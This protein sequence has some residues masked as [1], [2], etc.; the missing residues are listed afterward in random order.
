[1]PAPAARR[2]EDRSLELPDRAALLDDT[3]DAERP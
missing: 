3:D 2:A 1:M